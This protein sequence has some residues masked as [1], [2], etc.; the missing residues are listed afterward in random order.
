MPGRLFLERKMEEIGDWIGRAGAPTQAPRRNIQPGQDLVVLTNGGWRSMRWGLIPV[1]RVNARG[2]PVMETIINA[3]SETVF[4]KSAFDGVR[5][6]VVVV[7]G[8]YE[9]TGKRRKK[10]AWRIAPTDGAPLIFA[11]VWDVWRAPGGRELA[12]VATVTC[13]PNKDVEAIHHRMGVL[14]TRKDAGTWLE[15]EDAESKALCVPWPEGRL[16]IERAGDVDWSA[17]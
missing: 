17:A 16:G 4:D 14:L 2:R 15:G 5:R 1:G 9:W 13:A 8:W 3:R 6:G 12:Q 7:D 10:V 11:A